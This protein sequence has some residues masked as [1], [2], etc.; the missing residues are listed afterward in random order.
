MVDHRDELFLET[1]AATRADITN[2][3]NPF[4]HARLTPAPRTTDGLSACLEPA[5]RVIVGAQPELHSE[6]YSLPSA[7]VR[8]GLQG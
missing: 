5:Q 4:E 8:S 7:I 2:S 1:E 6:G 3:D